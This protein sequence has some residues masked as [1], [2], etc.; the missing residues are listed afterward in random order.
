MSEFTIFFV[1]NGLFE[2]GSVAEKCGP[3]NGDPKYRY[4]DGWYYLLD[5]GENADGFGPFFSKADAVR[6]AKDATRPLTARVAALFP[7]KYTVGLWYSA[8]HYDFKAFDKLMWAAYSG[9]ESLVPAWFEY[10]AEEKIG[11]TVIA[12]GNT[13][14]FHYHSEECP[15]LQA[16]I[17]F[18]CENGSWV[19]ENQE[20]WDINAK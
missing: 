1:L 6:L 15:S 17:T 19:E 5:D 9:C 18:S 7:D 2:D 16:H 13:L 20:C 8:H 11:V 4:Q 3:G 10:M 12:D 14:T